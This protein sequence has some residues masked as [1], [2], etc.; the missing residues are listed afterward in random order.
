MASVG[1]LPKCTNRCSRAEGTHI[2][3]NQ[4]KGEVTGPRE[5]LQLERKLSICPRERDG[6]RDPARLSAE[7]A[8]AR[9]IGEGTAFL[10]GLG[11]DRVLQKEN[12]QLGKHLGC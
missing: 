7:L 5:E 8:P 1:H 2:I 9:E 3:S 11:L 4:A 10:L 6:G 12:F